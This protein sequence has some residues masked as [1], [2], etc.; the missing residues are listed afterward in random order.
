ML[1]RPGSVC[2]PVHYAASAMQAA[3]TAFAFPIGDSDLTIRMMA[4]NL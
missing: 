1:P 4:F 2:L 3:L